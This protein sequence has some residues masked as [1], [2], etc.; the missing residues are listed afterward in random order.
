MNDVGKD[1]PNYMNSDN[2]SSN[3][4][5]SDVDV[6]KLTRVNQNS[7]K[8]VITDSSSN[9]TIS[10]ETQYNDK[11]DHVISEPKLTSNYFCFDC[12][13]ILTTIDDKKQHDLIESKRRSKIEKKE[14]NEQGN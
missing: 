10:T 13:A 1:N 12:G 9:I 3:N 7:N 2:N 6:D 5:N 4:K 11:F 8:E 14:G